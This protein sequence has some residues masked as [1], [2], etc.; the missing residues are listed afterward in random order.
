MVR[1][2]ENQDA[3]QELLKAWDFRL[4]GAGNIW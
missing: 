4:G 3:C 2:N 1:M